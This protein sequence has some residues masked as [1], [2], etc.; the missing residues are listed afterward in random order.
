MKVFKSKLFYTIV[1]IVFTV[2]MIATVILKFALPTGSGNSGRG[3]MPSGF[4]SS[5]DFSGFPQGGNSG[6]S[7]GNSGFTPGNMPEGFDPEN[8]PE[9]FDSSNMPEGFDKKSRPD[10]GSSDS[11]S[12]S[13]SDSKKPSRS[14]K[15]SSDS[16]SDRPS[17]PE[18]GNFPSRSSSRSKGFAGMINKIWISVVIVCALVD[19]VCIFMLIKLSKKKT[20]PAQINIGE[21]KKDIVPLEG[22][23]TETKEETEDETPKRKKKL[24][25]LIFIPILAGAV[26]LKMIPTTSG[27]TSSINVK[28]QLVAVDVS[29]KTIPNTF[30][31]GGTLETESTR[32]FTLPG[33]ITIESYAVSNGDIVEKGDLIARVNKSSVMIAISDIKTL[34]ADL[35]KDLKKTASDKDY[36]KIKAPAAGRVKAIYAEAGNSVVDTMTEHGALMLISLDGLM[37]V[38]LTG[39][40]GLQVGDTVTVRLSNDKEETGRVAT[41]SDG[42]TTITISDSSALSSSILFFNSLK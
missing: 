14:G 15:G 33:D 20:S 7:E 28:E 37:K 4:N 34:I 9:D 5:S 16:D 8:M 22:Q 12:D 2:I 17:R 3:N 42:V 10:S 6:D 39:V 1:L 13:D 18:N 40:S 35:D 38:E 21:K 31:S 29:T 36:S 23:V 30:L 41:V 26:I 25:M 11:D 27:S 24:W 32:A 19:A